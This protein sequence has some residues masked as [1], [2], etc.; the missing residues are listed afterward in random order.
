MSSRKRKGR[1][2]RIKGAKS[3]IR[4]RGRFQVARMLHQEIEGQREMVKE[5]CIQGVGGGECS[6][7]ML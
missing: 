3:G 4:N 2:R 1:G 5:E 6:V 7:S